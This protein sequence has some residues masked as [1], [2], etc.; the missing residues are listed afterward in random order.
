[1]SNKKKKTEVEEEVAVD[2]DFMEDAVERM[3]Q[4]FT[5]CMRPKA[6]LLLVIDHEDSSETTAFKTDAYQLSNSLI[7]NV[8]TEV[9][10]VDGWGWENDE[11][12]PQTEIIDALMAGG[13]YDGRK[14]W[15]VQSGNICL[16]I[17]LI[18]NKHLTL[19]PEAWEE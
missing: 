19:I 7:R 17:R 4:I 5:E 13:E 2:E 16:E 12:I 14:V 9:L 1:M 8:L 3:S 10:P 18:A 11:N 15:S 6:N